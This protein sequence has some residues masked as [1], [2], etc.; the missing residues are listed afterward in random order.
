MNYGKNPFFIFD[1]ACQLFKNFII[2]MKNL[3]YTKEI[4]T[5]AIKI[6]CGRRLGFDILSDT[7]IERL[8]S[9]YHI[10]S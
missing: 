3:T 9:L 10:F 8:R 6:V 1:T 2:K 7:F 5:I 4:R